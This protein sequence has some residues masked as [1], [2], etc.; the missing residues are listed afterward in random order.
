MPNPY[1]QRNQLWNTYVSTT[2]ATAYNQG[3]NEAVAAFQ[4]AAALGMDTAGMPLIYDLE[5]YTNGTGS[6]ST[7]RSAAKSFMKGW[8]DYL[9]AG[10]SQKSGIY[11]SACA[12]YLDDFAFDGNPPDFI[13][14]GD[15]SGNAHTSV[16][17]NNCVASVHWVNAQRH[18]QYVGEHLEPH[19]SVSISMDND[20]SNGPVYYTTSR[21][22]ETACL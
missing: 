11:G 1:C 19:G 9:E 16:V 6:L 20:C 21:T 4:A 13:F 10:V 3:W 2:A 17:T 15:W 8:A 22:F 14:I 18:K 12:S 5:F 7:C